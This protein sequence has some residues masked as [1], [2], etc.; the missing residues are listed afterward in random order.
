MLGV[1]GLS[2]GAARGF[3][4]VTIA[5][6]AVFPLVAVVL[7]FVILRERLVSN[8]LVGIGLVITGLLMLGFGS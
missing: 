3:V 7:A 8:Q 6:S 2:V 1:I 5:A 4:S